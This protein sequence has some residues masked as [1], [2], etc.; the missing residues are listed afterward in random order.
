MSTHTCRGHLP[1]SA[2]VLATGLSLPISNEAVQVLRSPLGN[3]TQNSSSSSNR[4]APGLRVSSRPPTQAAL[5]RPNLKGS[6]QV[7]CGQEQPGPRQAGAA[8]SQHTR[9]G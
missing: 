4:L 9:S 6:V 5:S 2:Q 7:G 8:G 1:A 3:F